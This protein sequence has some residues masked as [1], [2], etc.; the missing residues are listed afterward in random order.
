MDRKISVIIWG[1]TGF[2]GGELLRIIAR[3]PRMEVVG[4]VSRSKA[5]TPIGAVHPHLR[6]A[7]RDMNF[8][9]PEEGGGIDA[10]LVFLALPH[11]AAAETAQ[12]RISAGQKVVDLSADF[13]LRS[14]EEYRRWYETEHPCPEL[15][16]RAV[17]GLPELH[18]EEMSGADL[19]SGVGCNATSAVF[20]L[21]PLAKAGLI[22]NARIECRVGSSEGGAEAKEGSSHSLRSR[23]LRVVSPFVHR[24]MAE[25]VQELGLA[26]KDIS[27]TVTAVE[28]VR[29][30]QCIAHVTLKERLREA[31][32]WKL[33]RAQW[34]KEPF[35]SL[36]P[37]K[38]AHLRIPDPRFVMGSNRVLTGFALAE[39]G[40]R[41]I[42]ASA[43]DNLLKG[44]AGSAVQ[45]A[46]IM[47][48]SEETAGLEMMP[49]YPA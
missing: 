18:R 2:T 21:L 49:L 29:G 16:E 37:A 4:A 34:S 44:A 36:S 23:S 31:D 13:R 17:Y 39:D 3:H 40:R 25:V 9:S 48:G 47:M 38:P 12:K 6:S 10:E 27:M 42:A 30:I 14:P 19:I 22:E 15:L 33:Y 11:K 45:S 5:G 20:A 28:L 32:I 35:V 7:Y 46:N 1:A 24:H 43:I 8:I 26:E 41:A